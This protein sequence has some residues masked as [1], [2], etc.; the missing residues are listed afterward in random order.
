MWS[1][2]GSW[3]FLK[4]YVNAI[5]KINLSTLDFISEKVSNHPTATK[6]SILARGPKTQNTIN[7][8][9]VQKVKLP[10]FTSAVNVLKIFL[11]SM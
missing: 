10:H 1:I 5:S 9:K 2:Y 8:L 6:L 7:E 3:R 11:K 4:I